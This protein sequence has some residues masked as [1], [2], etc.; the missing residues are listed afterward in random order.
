MRKKTTP[1][2][3]PQPI[4]PG[5]QA[6]SDA[7]NASEIP[8]HLWARMLKRVP[9]PPIFFASSDHRERLLS[10][11][12]QIGKVYA[13]KLDFEYLAALYLLTADAY[14]WKYVRP[15]VSHEGIRFREMLD[16]LHWS[17]SERL[18]AELA[19][20]LFSGNPEAKVDLSGMTNLDQNNFEL[21]VCAIQLYWFA[22]AYGVKAEELGN[23]VQA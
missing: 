20:N 8:D 21:A 10:T 7:T 17:S 16:G 6:N 12:Q 2:S 22:H 15:Y 4:S 23:E 11:M 19:Y 18:L 13:G 14:S 5:P 1:K 3:A 9:L